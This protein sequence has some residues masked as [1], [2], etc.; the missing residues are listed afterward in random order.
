LWWGSVWAQRL[1]A[2]V[3]VLSGCLKLFRFASSLEALDLYGAG[4]VISLILAGGCSLL[5]AAEWAQDFSFKT[6]S[7]V[8]SGEIVEALVTGIGSTRALVSVIGLAV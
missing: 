1:A 5:L 7:K 8:E 4:V 6:M 3:F 2:G